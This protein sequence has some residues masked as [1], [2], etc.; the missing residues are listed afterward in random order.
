MRRTDSL[1][2]GGMEGYGFKIFVIE[3]KKYNPDAAAIIKIITESKI[4]N[5]LFINTP[6]LR[7]VHFKD[8]WALST[9]YTIVH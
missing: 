8:G 5:P 9:Y 7:K 4:I 6:L 1:I 3:G 2:S